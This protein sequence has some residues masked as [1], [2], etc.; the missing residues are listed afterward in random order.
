MRFRGKGLTEEEQKDSGGEQRVWVP[1]PMSVCWSAAVL[2]FIACLLYNAAG[3]NQSVNIGKLSN[4]N[5][6][7]DS[8]SFKKL[9]QQQQQQKIVF[10]REK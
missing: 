1:D 4:H 7:Y 2:C 8:R 3:L 6:F 5:S 10:A 9:Q